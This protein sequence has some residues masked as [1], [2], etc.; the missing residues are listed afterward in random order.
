M[1]MA[2]TLSPTHPG[3]VQW[4]HLLA[5]GHSSHKPSLLGSYHVRSGGVMPWRVSCCVLT[6]YFPA[7]INKAQDEKH[8]HPTYQRQTI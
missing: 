6:A 1:W 7:Q 5:R 3:I 2:E 8:Q 4:H